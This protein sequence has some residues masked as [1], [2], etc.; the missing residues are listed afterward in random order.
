MHTGD[1]APVSSR[2][3][4]VKR[5]IAER[6]LFWLNKYAIGRKKRSMEDLGELKF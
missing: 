2:L 1:G 3:A 5:K 4:I 6:P